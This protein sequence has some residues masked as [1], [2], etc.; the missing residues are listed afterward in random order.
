MKR[1]KYCKKLLALGVLGIACAAGILYVK[2]DEQRQKPEPL[3]EPE[4][5]PAPEPEEEPEE[6]P[7]QETGTEN[8]PEPEAAEAF[9]WNM[10]GQLSAGSTIDTSLLTE[11]EI[12]SL[13][14]SE[15]ITDTVFKRIN[16]VSYQENDT[17]GREELRYLR[18]LHM[19]FD[20]QI[21]IGELIVNCQIAEDIL[22]IMKKLYENKYPIEKM[23]LVDEYGGDDNRSMED[24]NSSAF[25]YRVI[26]G[27]T[28]LSKHSLGLAIDINPRY[29]P[30]VRPGET[31]EIIVEPSGSEAYVD[32]QSEFDYKIDEHDLCYQLFSQYGFTWGGSWNTVKDYQHF[33]K[34][35][36]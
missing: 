31:G 11:A 8:T 17:V 36:E 3:Q 30:Y 20:G 9:D 18:V 16:G 15:E 5:K 27:T 7:V 19:G 14:Y 26:A 2:R 32:R 29:N 33:Q 4:I 23:V 6:E 21:H 35:T 25:N 1:K 12:D 13:F 28:R 24:N 34:T 10:V 22:T